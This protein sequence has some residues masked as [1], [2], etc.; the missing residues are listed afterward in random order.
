VLK[1]QVE[2]YGVYQ[3]KITD[4]DLGLRKHLESLGSKLDLQTQP[5]G[6][7]PKDK[8]KSRNA[9]YFDLRTELYRITGIDW[10]QTTAS[11][12]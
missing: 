11:M 7:R 6:P 8:R 4:C 9:P 5:I 1:Q 3:A 10:A 12:F 2:L